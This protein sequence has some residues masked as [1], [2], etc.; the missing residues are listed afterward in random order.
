MGAVGAY[1]GEIIVDGDAR[2]QNTEEG[3]ENS[4]EVKNACVGNDGQNNSSL[5]NKL[6]I[7]SAIDRLNLFRRSFLDDNL[8]NRLFVVDRTSVRW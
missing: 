7:V 1:G 2:P 3:S 8:K 4:S 5:A 6:T